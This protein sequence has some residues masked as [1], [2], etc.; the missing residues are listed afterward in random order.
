MHSQNT[1]LQ[2]NLDKTHAH[3]QAKHR[4]G[5]VCVVNT[6]TQR[7]PLKAVSCGVAGHPLDVDLARAQ[8][9]CTPQGLGYQAVLRA[10]HHAVCASKPGFDPYGNQTE[11]RPGHLTG[12]H[13]HCKAACARNAAAMHVSMCPHCRRLSWQ[14]HAAPPSY[15]STG[16][17]QLTPLSQGQ[18]TGT[19]QGPKADCAHNA[20]A[21]HVS[22]A[23]QHVP[24]MQQQC[25]SAWLLQ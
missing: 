11:P 9:T 4:D 1:G 21:M 10:H 20:A 14:Q 22:N 23:C 8:P 18:S 19:P 5:L 6:L 13:K 7:Q 2:G 25:M 24:T 16:L 15:R 17:S 3:T 12:I